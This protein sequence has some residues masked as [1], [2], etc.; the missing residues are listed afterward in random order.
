MFECRGNKLEQSPTFDFRAMLE[1]MVKQSKFMTLVDK[2]QGRPDLL[3][4]GDFGGNL[5]RKTTM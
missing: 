2:K 1:F 4:L 5:R 3:N